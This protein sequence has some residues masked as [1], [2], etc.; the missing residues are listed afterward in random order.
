V[1][2]YNYVVSQGSTSR[3]LANLTTIS[4]MVQF[5][6]VL[7]IQFTSVSYSF[8]NQSKITAFHKT[9][10]NLSLF[11][12]RERRAEKGVALSHHSALN[13]GFFIGKRIGM[14]SQDRICLTVPMF[15]CF[16]NIIG[17]LAALNYGTS[18]VLPTPNF[19]PS[20]TIRV[21]AQ[22]KYAHIYKFLHSSNVGG[23]LF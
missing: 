5:D 1:F 10:G 17:L 6:D 19:S 23:H 18:V 11:N 2:A 8:P 3:A 13:N 4:K 7:N 22:E 9:K 12:N 14:T 20:T 15:H 16:G 21:A